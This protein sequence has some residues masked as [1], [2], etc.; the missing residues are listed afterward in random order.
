M[1]NGFG[2]LA[3]FL[4]A[5]KDVVPEWSEALQE[6]A[7]CAHKN[8]HFTG[9]LWQHVTGNDEGMLKFKTD[10]IRSIFAGHILRSKIYHLRMVEIFERLLKE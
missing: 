2:N 9:A 3:M 4:E 7:R 6:A 5:H 8:A 1:Q 10:D